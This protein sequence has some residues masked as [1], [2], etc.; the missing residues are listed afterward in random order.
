[1][2]KY[3]LQEWRKE[4]MKAAIEHF[5]NSGRGG[6][7]GLGRAL[8]KKSGAWISQMATGHRAIT[9]DTVMDIENLSGMAG[10][11]KPKW[12]TIASENTTELTNR[13]SIPLMANAASMGTGENELQ[14][15]VF[16]GSITI[17][18]PWIERHFGG[19]DHAR[20]RFLHAYG[21]S[22]APTF[23]SGDVLLIDSAIQDIK[24]DGIYALEA[25][26][27]LFIKRVRQRLDGQFEISSDNPTHKTVDT[28][29]GDH[30]V[31]V[32][33]RVIWVWNGK[34]L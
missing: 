10:W 13:V 7:A 12:T 27:R 18:K 34:K 31:R 20:L 28:L 23:N 21:D 30:E 33:G 24:I 25:H 16:D 11:F 2:D 22:M 14:D 15:D 29:N 26:G 5:K 32:K 19:T 8:G 17:A 3:E 4:R 9:E 6:A 1:M